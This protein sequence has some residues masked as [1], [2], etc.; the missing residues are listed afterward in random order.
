MD[1]EYARDEENEIA[2]GPAVPS[3]AGATGS[4][5][6]GRAIP[7]QPDANNVV[8]LPDG[9]TLDDIKVRGRDLVIELPDGRIMVI[10][11]GAVFV[12]TVVIDGVTLPPLNLAAYLNSETPQPAAGTV[13]SSGGNF[14]DPVAPL[15]AA[16]GLGDLLPYTELNF[17]EQQR[18]EVIPNLLDQEPTVS[19][20]TPDQPAGAIAATASVSEAGLPA[21]G[22]ESAGSNAAANS[23]TTSGSILFDTPDGFGSV[24][25]NGTVVTQVGQTIVTPQSTLTITS[26]ASGAVG[27]TYT[28]TDN[29]LGDNTG[30]DLVVVVTDADGDMATATLSVRIV[31]DV[32]R[33]DDD[34]ATILEGDADHAV[35][36]D[37]D[38][39]DVPGADGTAS[40]TF[41]SLT[42]TY[43]SLTLN[44]DGTQTYTLSASGVA[45]IDGLKPGQTLTDSFAYT[46][47]DGDGDSDPAQLVVTLTGTNDVPVITGLTPA[48]QGGDASVDEDDLPAGSDSTKESLTSGG[49]FTISAPDGVDDLTVG[50]VAVIV[51][52]QFQAG[53]SGTT[54]LGNTLAFTAYDAASGQVTYSYTL[55]GAET[56]ASGNGENA[57]FE[58]FTVT[59]TDTDGE[60][61]TDTLSVRIVDDVPSPVVPTPISVKNGADAPVS[62]A[63]DPNASNNYGADGGTVRFLSSLNGSNSGLTSNFVPIL[64]TRLDDHTLVGKAGAT[65]IFTITLNPATSTYSVDMDGAIDST[66]DIKFDLNSYNFVGGNN[67]WAGFIG[68][69]ETVAVPINNDSQDL[70][71]T[72]AINGARDGSVNTTANTGGITGGGG[73]GSAV[74]STETFRVDFVT[75]LRGNPAD[76][77]GDYD[78]AGNRDHVFDGH[79]TV[80]G[81]SAFFQSSSGSTVKITAF[82]DADG[83]T[84]VGDG[85]K[86]TINAL[87]IRYL[88]VASAV[89]VPTTTAT[90]YTV[91][92]HVFTVTLNGDGS[93]SVA[94]VAGSNGGNATGTTIAVF[95]ANGYNSVEYTW[96][97]GDTFQIGDFGATTL[98]KDPV[99]FHV[100]VEVVDNDGDV[101]ASSDLVITAGAIPP[102]VIDLDGDG[103][104][105]LSLQAGVTFDYGRD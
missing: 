91:N 24:T 83:N 95:T 32:P 53:A 45:V 68:K 5:P 58:D 9:V 52:G 17:P 93:V 12:P 70:L 88:G 43:G 98:T 35:T 18:E 6:S 19:I 28:L 33:A 10:A 7:L 14:A 46:L 57:L 38:T 67:S 87:T 76:G 84:A 51:N 3:L 41:A 49:T 64:Y 16:F 25:I 54:P 22:Q 40:R 39:N 72:P 69:G 21:R 23:E 11:D 86:D 37:V 89:I 103:A 82:D 31:D 79:Y 78:T 42:G 65:T 97:A 13:T 75:D 47:T 20:A 73:A 2:S 44:G 15:Q 60:S 102:V 100:P 66:T 48:G 4:A 92:S 56:H 8:T 77:S 96:Q 61:D 55:T 90:N 34:A 104:E 63:L 30:Q 101:S 62:Q 99:I 81:A 105:F 74:G 27:Y 29:T 59:L 94:G 26:I 36:F 1:Y 71:L 80:N 50:T 85:V